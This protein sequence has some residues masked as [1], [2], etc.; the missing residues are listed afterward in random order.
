[1]ENKQNMDTDSEM[2]VYEENKDEGYDADMECN[3][4]G[5][6]GSDIDLEG[7][8]DS[9]TNDSLEIAMIHLKI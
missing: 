2:E 1:M 3:E 8:W 7:H 9:D 5:N 6:W 4:E